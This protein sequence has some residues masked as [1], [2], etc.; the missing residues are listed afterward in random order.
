[1]LLLFIG[2]ITTPLKMANEKIGEKSG[3]VVAT[4][5]C[6]LL[7]FSIHDTFQEASE[8]R[9]GSRPSLGDFD[10]SD[11][12]PELAVCRVCLHDETKS[13]C[14]CTHVDCGKCKAM[15]GESRDMLDDGLQRQVLQ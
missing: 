1:M 12:D 9:L 5:S 4:E 14:H 15:L 8:T 7:S 6:P 10:E 11:R 13:T 3:L 2:L